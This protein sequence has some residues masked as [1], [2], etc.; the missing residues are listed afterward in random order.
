M[1]GYLIIKNYLLPLKARIILAMASEPNTKR[2][3]VAIKC[4][5]SETINLSNSNIIAKC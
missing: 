4:Q 1:E 3:I 2:A 5:I